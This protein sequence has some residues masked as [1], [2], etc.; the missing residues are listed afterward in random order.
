MPYAIAM[1]HRLSKRLTEV[2]RNGEIPY[3]RPD[4]KTQ[5]TVEYKEDEP[6]RI[7]TI[8]I[9]N[10]HSEEIEIKTIKEDLINKFCRAS[11]SSCSKQF[12]ILSSSSSKL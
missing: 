9:S 11:L 6:Y 12:L 10:Q 4:G 2:R 8:L 1:A 5:V 3:I 7:D